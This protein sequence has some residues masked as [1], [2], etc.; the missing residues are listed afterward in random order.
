MPKGTPTRDTTP[1]DFSRTSKTVFEISR[2]S[3]T[4]K[5][6]RVK[7]RGRNLFMVTGFV[8]GRRYRKNFSEEKEAREAAAAIAD[9][10]SRG[11]AQAISLTGADRDSYIHA[12]SQLRHLGIPLHDAV[13]DYVAAMKLLKGRPLPQQKGLATRY[14]V[15]SR[16]IDSWDA[17]WTPGRQDRPS[18]RVQHPALRFLGEFIHPLAVARCPDPQGSGTLFFHAGSQIL[19]LVAAVGE[20]LLGRAPSEGLRRLGP[21]HH[22]ARAMR[23]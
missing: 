10:L 8:A 1:E 12:Q 22:A 7:N 20:Q 16:T 18:P 21:A 17:P 6:Y 15:S 9:Q 23:R 11:Q 4:I 2:G 13:R 5:V 19:E 14:R 3:T